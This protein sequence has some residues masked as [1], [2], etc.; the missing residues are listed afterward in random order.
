MGDVASNLLLWS[1]TLVLVVVAAA[2]IVRDPRRMRCAIFSGMAL[3]SAYLMVQPYFYQWLSWFGPEVGSW[4]AVGLL[5]LAMLIVVGVS[6]FLIWSGIVLLAREG[7]SISHSLSLGLGLAIVVY[8]V[9]IIWAAAQGESQLATYLL[10]LIGPI[11]AFG[12]TLFSYL[13]YSGLYGFWAKHWAKPGEVVVVLGSG[14][15]GERVTPLLARRL[16]LGIEMYDKSLRVWPAPV[17]VVSGGKGSDEQ[18]SEAEAMSRYVLTVTPPDQW[19]LLG[20]TVVG[21]A[22][23]PAVPSLPARVVDSRRPLKSPV[24]QMVLEDRS[25]STEQN[26]AFTKAIVAERQLRGPWMVVTSDFHGFRAAMLLSKQGTPG[27]AVGARSARYF[28]P[29][30]KLREFVA[31]LAANRKWTV[32]IAGFSFLPLVLMIAVQLAS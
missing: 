11:L 23:A 13:L 16:D 1:P 10:M 20:D 3:T 17:M 15:I 8:I 4:Y 28:W 30:A 26:L 27:N 25:V 9:A 19:N 2:M 12:F 24:H 29:S 7:V 5:L 32:T 6:I 14:I 22:N 21:S 18:I 31:I